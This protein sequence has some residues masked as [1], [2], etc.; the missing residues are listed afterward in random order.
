MTAVVSMDSLGR[1][2]IAP[3]TGTVRPDGSYSISR[4][5]ALGPEGGP[6]QGGRRFFLEQVMSVRGRFEQTLAGVRE[7]A[8]GSAAYRFH[9]DSAGGAV[10]TTCTVSFTGSGTRVGP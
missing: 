1:D 6:R 8:T 3:L 4:T 10:F 2:A 9:A 5:L 7:A